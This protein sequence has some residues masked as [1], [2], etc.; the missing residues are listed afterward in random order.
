MGECLPNMTP[1]LKTNFKEGARVNVCLH[2]ALW[3]STGLRSI[4]VLVLIKCARLI[5][6]IILYLLLSYQAAKSVFQKPLFSLE[7]RFVFCLFCFWRICYIRN[8]MQKYFAEISFGFAN[9]FQCWLILTRLKLC[10]LSLSAESP[11]TSLCNR[12]SSYADQ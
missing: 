9:M 1:K 4:A 12:N 6:R 7:M 5:F 2:K 3:S 10:G 8:S 11:V